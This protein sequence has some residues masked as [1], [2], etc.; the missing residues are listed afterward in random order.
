MRPLCSFVMFPPMHYEPVIVVVHV[1]PEVSHY[2]GIYF[3]LSELENIYAVVAAAVV[4]NKL[5]VRVVTLVSF[6]PR[7]IPVSLLG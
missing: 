4:G 2:L 1:G 7:L 3:L 6:C 5:R